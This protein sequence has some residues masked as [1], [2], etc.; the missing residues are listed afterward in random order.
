MPC[1]GY[2]ILMSRVKDIRLKVI[3]SKIANDFIR[4][5]H[6]SGKVMQ[7]SNLHFG[8]FLDGVLHGVMSFGNPIDKRKVLG[9]VKTDNSGINENGTKC[10]S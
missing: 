9:L 3:P 8:A 7:N 6:Y 4:K 10:L 1:G 2:V 5:H